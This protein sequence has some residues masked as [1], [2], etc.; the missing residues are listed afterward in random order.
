MDDARRK[1]L[2]GTLIAMSI[3][4]G[5]VVTVP[6]ISSMRSV[7]TR[8]EY[9]EEHSVLV[10]LSGIPPGGI[11]EVKWELSLNNTV[12]IIRRRAEDIS[13]LYKPSPMLRD[14]YSQE[15]EQ[16][17][18]A[19]TPYRSLREEYFVAINQCTHLGCGLLYSPRVEYGIYAPDDWHGGFYCPCHTSFFDLAGRVYQYSPAQKNLIVPPYHFINET[20]IKIGVTSAA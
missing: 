17:A 20:H 11:K 15:S 13:K 1:F 3:G 9:L 10:D 5:A 18:F 8:Q 6:F 14:P 4:G 12:M 2:K 19:E 7:Q 16:P